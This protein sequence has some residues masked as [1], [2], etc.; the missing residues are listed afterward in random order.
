MT[1]I[2][3]IAMLCSLPL[4]AS[5][6]EETAQARFVLLVDDAAQ[7]C[8]ALIKRRAL[9]EAIEACDRAVDLAR[10]PLTTGMNPYGHSNRDALAVAYS[11][12]AVLNGLLGD[13]IAAAADFQRALRQNRYTEQ[14]SRN[15]ALIE[16]GYLARSEQ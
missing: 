8:T 1:R 13:S 4:G 11:N 5:L 7:T 2:L 15:R 3:L 9:D 10:V 6:S 12:R 16:A 14:I